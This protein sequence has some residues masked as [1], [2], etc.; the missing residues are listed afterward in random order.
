MNEP[1]MK[2]RLLFLVLLVSTALAACA[3]TPFSWENAR[4]IQ[5]GM[6]S[7]EVTAI[8]GQPYMINVS[9]NKTIYTWSYAEAFAGSRAVSVVFVDNKVNQAPATTSVLK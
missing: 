6:T 4:K 8:M 5:P 7:N 3:G 9:G 2:T 1:M